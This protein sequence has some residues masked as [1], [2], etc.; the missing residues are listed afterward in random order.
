[1]TSAQGKILHLQY[2]Q[3]PPPQCVEL[4]CVVLN[5]VVLQCCVVLNCVVLKYCVVLWY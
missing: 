3:S 4:C 1:M 2:R 5:C